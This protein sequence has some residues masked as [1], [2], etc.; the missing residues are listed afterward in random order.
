MRQLILLLTLPLFLLDLIT[1]EMVVRKF[2][3]PPLPD[4]TSSPL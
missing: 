1:K 2:A 3:A 4:S